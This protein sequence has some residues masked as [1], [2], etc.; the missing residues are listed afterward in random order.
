MTGH[1]ATKDPDEPYP[2]TSFLVWLR[3]AGKRY[4]WILGVG[5]A[6]HVMVAGAKVAAGEQHLLRQWGSSLLLLVHLL[7]ILLI[8]VFV[9]RDP[10]TTDF[11]KRAAS[12]YRDHQDQ[13][14]KQAVSV[15]E[16]AGHQLFQ[17]WQWLWLSWLGLYF[18]LTIQTAFEAVGYRT[19]GEGYKPTSVSLDPT[20]RNVFVSDAKGGLLLK[21]DLKRGEHQKVSLSPEIASSIG[22]VA[23]LPSSHLLVTDTEGHRVFEFD[24]TASDSASPDERSFGVM[25]EP[26]DDNTHL[27]KPRSA[28]PMERA[29]GG[30]TWLI[31]DAANARVFEYDPDSERILCQYG[32]TGKRRGETAAGGAKLLDY[33]AFATPGPHGHVWIV[34][35]GAGEVLELEWPQEE[36]TRTGILAAGLVRTI[37]GKGMAPQWE[38]D[39]PTWVGFT[40]RGE[41]LIADAGNHRIVS[42]SE[43]GGS[44]RV[45]W[46]TGRAGTAK[47]A[48]NYPVACALA[49]DQLLIADFEN[50]R[51]VAVRTE[52]EL[53]PARVW[54]FLLN[55]PCQCD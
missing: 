47:K 4:A 31:A 10:Y 35:Q 28:V 39:E 19:Y 13:N 15:A 12:R 21:L 49:T 29:G 7:V 44:P 52:Q 34:D 53:L 41:V 20:K 43:T 23:C 50:E 48:L 1:V 17:H 46:G 25:G 32:T 45:I 14:L 2:G 37:T 55:P 42:F 54:G 26:N 9:M 5:S 27:N 24:P 18:L 51:I 16:R 30:V 6:V 3:T 33:P 11:W 22:S 36:M 8:V 38:L 40:E